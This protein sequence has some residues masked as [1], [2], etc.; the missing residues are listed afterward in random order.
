MG[1]KQKHL[2]FWICHNEAPEVENL[3]EVGGGV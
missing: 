1:Y 3:S 2:L